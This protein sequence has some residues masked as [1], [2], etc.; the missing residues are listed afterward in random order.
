VQTTPFMS[1]D[2]G[3]VFNSIAQIFGFANACTRPIKH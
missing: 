2:Y 1:I 3:T